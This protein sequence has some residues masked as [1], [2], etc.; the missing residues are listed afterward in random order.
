MSSS[1][2]VCEVNAQFKH[3][4][5]CVYNKDA[6]VIEEGVV[7]VS[8]K[9]ANMANLQDDSSWAKLN[10]KNFTHKVGN[11]YSPIGTILTVPLGAS[12]FGYIDYIEGNSFDKN[13]YPKLYEVLGSNVFPAL[14]D[15]MLGDNLPLGS[16]IHILDDEAIPTGW[17]KW[18]VRAGNLVNT[19]LLE[20]FKKLSRKTPDRVMKQLFDNA[21]AS[22]TFPNLEDFFLRAGVNVDSIIGSFVPDTLSYNASFKLLPLVLSDDVLNPVAL[23]NTDKPIATGIIEPVD[24]IYVQDSDCN[25]IA[26]IKGVK[27][28]KDCLTKVSTV[29]LIG[30]GYETAP[31]H[32]V[33]HIAV[34]VVNKVNRVSGNFK[35]VIK[36]YDSID[37]GVDEVVFKLNTL[38]RVGFS[39][40][41]TAKHVTNYTAS[42]EDSVIISSGG[43]IT[44]PNTLKVG[45][46]FTVIRRG[47]NV[48][49]E[50]VV[51]TGGK[52][53]YQDN[54]AATILVVD[55]GVNMA[56]G[57]FA[58]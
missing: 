3:N 13:L 38:S 22:N 58:D 17:K 34:K 25:A 29:N 6:M 37:T 16:I 27:L 11:D 49:L 52:T 7:Y 55:S 47:N 40:Y 5:N 2:H 26:G 18:E 24:N 15:K 23:S 20:V 53:L 12:K 31:K 48:K 36:V 19:D 8:L 50:G 30:S 56:F 45:R 32:L 46:S 33:T 1:G 57:A 42:N 10:I 35:Q 43:V 39:N 44:F 14:D 54:S 51:T 21:I 9:D 4:V 28:K 41:F